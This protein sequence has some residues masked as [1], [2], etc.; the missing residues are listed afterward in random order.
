MW[1]PP[2]RLTCSRKAA[3]S[4]F[5]ESARIIICKTS[6]IQ[7]ESWLVSKKA[8]RALIS[9]AAIFCLHNTQEFLS[10]LKT[11]NE[12]D[13]IVCYVKLGKG[14]HKCKYMFGNNEKFLKWRDHTSGSFHQGL[15]KGDEF[16]VFLHYWVSLQELVLWLDEGVACF[17]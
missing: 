15:T 3:S 11:L 14:K 8:I 4:G 2:T 13:I 5:W 10:S 12:W 9:A 16:F 7:V 6:S 17:Q 1:Q